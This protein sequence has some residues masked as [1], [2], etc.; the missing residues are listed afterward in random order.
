M[1]TRLMP[2]VGGPWDGQ[3]HPVDVAPNGG[4]PDRWYFVEERSHKYDIAAGPGMRLDSG[5]V[6][7]RHE[8]WLTSEPGGRPVYVHQDV[9]EW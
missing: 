5:R 8:Y 3:E 1:K 9:K 6:Q 7:I 4:I 2:F